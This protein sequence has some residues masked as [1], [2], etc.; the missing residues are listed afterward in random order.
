MEGYRG[1][2]V[3]E[4]KGLLIAALLAGGS[5]SGGWGS[6]ALMLS[7]RTDSAREEGSWARARALAFARG[8][9]S[10]QNSDLVG[11]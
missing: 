3:G 7:G 4:E 8:G 9:G 10:H 6:E 5:L 1:R 11:G 2:L